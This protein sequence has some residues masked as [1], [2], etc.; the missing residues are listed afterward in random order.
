[1]VELGKLI[2]G[3]T[4]IDLEHAERMQAKLG[5]KPMPEALFNFCL[6]TDASEAPVAMRR[7]GSRRFL[8]WSQSTDFRFLESSL[9]EAD[10]VKGI[11]ADGNC[12]GLLALIV[13]FSS[14]L[15]SVIQSNNRLLL[16]NGHHRAYALKSIGI[17]HAPCLIKTVTRLDELK[18]VAGNSVVED[19][20]FYFKAARP[21]LLD[22]FFDPRVAKNIA[23]CAIDASD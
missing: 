17:T 13:G 21:P 19:P 6:P 3:Q 9:L 16:H 12:S 15:L 14:N 4:H 7:A 10:A 11:A 1:M 18:L 2:V 22:D 5:P 8:F 20:A 23:G